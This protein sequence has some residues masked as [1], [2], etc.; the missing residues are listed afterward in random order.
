MPIT[1]IAVEIHRARFDFRRGVFEKTAGLNLCGKTGAQHNGSEAKR[2]AW[3]DEGK[4]GTHEKLQQYSVCAGAQLAR[5]IAPVPGQKEPGRSGHAGVRCND[6]RWLL[7]VE[8]DFSL[9]LT[10][11][12]SARDWPNPR[13]RH[14]ST[15][16]KCPVSLGKTTDLG[17]CPIRR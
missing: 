3:G 1:E 17:V 5:K 8:D 13:D 10:G 7:R 15:T 11:Y 12:S 6:G 9:K 16:T 2:L 4:W 14:S